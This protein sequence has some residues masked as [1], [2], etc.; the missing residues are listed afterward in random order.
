MLSVKGNQLMMIVFEKQV[1][2][3]TANL[4]RKADSVS[5]QGQCHRRACWKEKSAGRK[6]PYFGGKEPQEQEQGKRKMRV[7]ERPE[8]QQE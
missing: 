2:K 5:K 6:E 8:M 7:Q 4:C 1:Q 3:A